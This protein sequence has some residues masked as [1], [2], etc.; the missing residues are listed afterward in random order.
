MDW[1]SHREDPHRECSTGCGRKVCQS[2]EELKE[3]CERA[4]LE[5]ERVDNVKRV[6]IVK[7]KK[8]K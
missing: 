5:V 2:E 1:F 4:G 8:K 6:I 3:T 7:A